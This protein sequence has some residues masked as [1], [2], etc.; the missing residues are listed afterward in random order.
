MQNKIS[1]YLKQFFRKPWRAYDKVLDRLCRKTATHAVL[2]EQEKEFN[3]LCSDTRTTYSECIHIL[4]LFRTKQHRI[5]SVMFSNTAP[6]FYI[7][8]LGPLNWKRAKVAL[9]F[10]KCKKADSGSYRLV[11]FISIPG[12]MM[13]KILLGK[14]FQ[15]RERQ[16]DYWEQWVW[17]YKGEITLDRPHCLLQWDDCLDR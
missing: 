4:L 15:T 5:L 3:Y 2:M 8:S 16:K 13:E 7:H 10:K 11:S 12:K 9:I 17:S 6:W 14:N 1:V